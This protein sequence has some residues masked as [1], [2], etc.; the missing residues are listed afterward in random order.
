MALKEKSLE[1]TH[2]APATPTRSVVRS[3]PTRH[4]NRVLEFDA[5]ANTDD[6]NKTSTKTFNKN[7]VLPNR[8]K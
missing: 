1:V 8:N 5:D 4:T 7:A 3:N 2:S 6:G